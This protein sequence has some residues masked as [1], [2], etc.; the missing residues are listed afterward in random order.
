MLCLITKKNI[1]YAA[2]ACV[3]VPCAWPGTTMFVLVRARERACADHP[4]VGW[5]T[6]EHVVN[7]A[8]FVHAHK[9]TDPKTRN[10][11]MPRCRLKNVKGSAAEPQCVRALRSFRRRLKR[12]LSP[13]RWCHSLHL[14]TAREHRERKF[15]VLCQL[16]GPW[17]TIMVSPS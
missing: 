12:M 14:Q 1:C 2:S 6:V 15:Y 17:V 4:W 7:V 8:P 13:C 9:N 10:R 11:R 5:Y 3:C 16:K